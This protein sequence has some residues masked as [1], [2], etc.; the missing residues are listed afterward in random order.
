MEGFSDFANC[1]LTLFNLAGGGGGQGGLS[2]VLDISEFCLSI[3]SI[4]HIT[5]KTS[6]CFLDKVPSI[7]ENFA[8]GFCN[9]LI[10]SAKKKC[11]AGLVVFFR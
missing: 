7:G 11:N 5:R 4:G 10:L 3:I 9:I 8:V 2:K 6:S 1:F